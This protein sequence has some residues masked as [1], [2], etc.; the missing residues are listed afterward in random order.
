MTDIRLTVAIPTSGMVP[1]SFMHSMLELMGHVT[2]NGISS[3]KGESIAIGTCIEQ[4]SVIHVNREKLLKH[5]MDADQTH[6]MFLDDDMTFDPGILNL[7]LGRRKSVVLT[8][9]RIKKD[10]PVFVAVGLDGRRV[11]TDESS[12]GLERVAFSGFGVSLLELKT[13]DEV[14]Q[15][16]FCPTFDPRQTDQPSGGYTIEDQAFFDRVR[17][18]GVEV[19]LDHDASKMVGHVG[20]KTWAWN[21]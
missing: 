4:G 8:N 6:I 11:V 16:W 3:R 10:E 17:A 19:W 2:T 21:N 7:M 13:L 12:A 18:A 14:A 20:R 5:A 1:I 15:P 9:Y